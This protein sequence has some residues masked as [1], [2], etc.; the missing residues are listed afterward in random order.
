[1]AG[2]AA[3]HRLVAMD[4]P[5]DIG[6]R[7]APGIRRVLK[8]L[9][10]VL[11]DSLRGTVCIPPRLHIPFVDDGVML[12]MPASDEDLA[13]VKIVT[14]CPGNAARGLPQVSGEVL[15]RSSRDG[16][17]LGVFDAAT[18]T[19]VRTAAVS[20]L[21]AQLA[22]IGPRSGPV[23]I[24][25]S[26]VQ[27]AAHAEACLV[28]LGTERVLMAARNRSRAEAIAGRCRN[29][30]ERTAVVE[31]LDLASR[32]FSEAVRECRV[33]VTT[34]S[35]PEPVLPESVSPGTFIAAVGAYTPAMAEIPAAVVHRAAAPSRQFPRGTLWV[36]TLAGAREEAGDL[37]QAG[38]DWSCVRELAD[39]CGHQRL[40]EPVHNAVNGD[41][42]L[43][44][45]VGC[46]LWDLAAARAAVLK[47]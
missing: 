4:F 36:D 47:E 42:T 40:P 11:A 10:A 34:T 9:P 13:I 6:F 33:I 23:L 28:C 44:K 15:V 22:G 45:S 1:L 2:R 3:S 43:F 38:I 37:L 46:A 39:L 24:V 26:G 20:I 8:A 7:A 21:A 41:V 16:Q 17:L 12:V 32:A 18:I 27:A 35:S 25:G 19:A 31:V 29:L 30:G 5:K 14:V